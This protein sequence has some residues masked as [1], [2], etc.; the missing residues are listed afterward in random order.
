MR[1]SDI[2]HVSRMSSDRFTPNVALITSPPSTLPFH[3]LPPHLQYL[4]AGGSPNT[5][6]E[7]GVTVLMLTASHC[8]VPCVMA[9]LL[10]QADVTAVDVNGWTA[11]DY[12]ARSGEHGLASLLWAL[13][14]WEKVGGGEAALGF[15]TSGEEGS[16]EEEPWPSDAGSA[17]VCAAQH[18]HAV[19]HAVEWVERAAGLLASHFLP[20]VTPLMLTAMH[21]AVHALRELLRRAAATAAASEAGEAPGAAS[22]H[23]DV[24]AA[25]VHGCTALH[26]AAICSRHAAGAVAAARAL[27]AAGARPD[28]RNAQG[29]SALFFAAHY[30]NTAVARVLLDAGADPQSVIAYAALKASPSFV[31]LLLDAGAHPQAFD[32]PLRRSALELA[33]RRGAAEVALLLLDAGADV[34]LPDAEGRHDPVRAGDAYTMAMS[35]MS[36][37]AAIDPE[38]VGELVEALVAR[39]VSP[40]SRHHQSFTMLMVA[41]GAV[42]RDETL[43]PHQRPL[44]TGP[45]V[46][47]LPAIRALLGAGADVNT[48]SSLGQTALHFA[49]MCSNGHEAV[50]LL[51]EAGADVN[52]WGSS[53]EPAV[54]HTPLFTA[55]MSGSLATVEVLLKCKSVDPN[56]SVQLGAC[57]TSPPLLV[58]CDARPEAVPLLLAAG[59]HPSLGHII[60]ARPGEEGTHALK[61]PL[62]AAAAAGSED[63]VVA[64][65]EAGAHPLV[66]KNCTPAA[67]GQQLVQVSMSDLPDKAI[68]AGVCKA[69]IRRHVSSERIRALLFDAIERRQVQVSA[70]V[71][72]RMV[73]AQMS[74]WL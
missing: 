48:V 26:Y 60:R 29:R 64:L 58:A 39:G 65:L 10:W 8:R 20:G 49:C 71:R 74:G 43:M 14:P 24:D 31:A 33:L 11:A 72:V 38:S 9:L 3:L 45:F 47:N 18:S 21:G 6:F 70:Q 35:T 16:E 62:L 73:G 27:L 17:P 67:V 25:D 15:G 46:A 69:V 7:R 5:V 50:A 28:M 55:L 66:V 13:Q 4:D 37:K 32:G 36:G 54:M 22:M 23:L 53:S 12:A 44:N 56:R 63:A 1:V 40:D 42:T 57:I 61:S 59:A 68:E 41:C 30:D 2:C 19:S 34:T 51:I 52:A